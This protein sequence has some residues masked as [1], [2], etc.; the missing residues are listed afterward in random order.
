M[1]GQEIDQLIDETVPDA[2]QA[3]RKKRLLQGPKEFREMRDKAAWR[4]CWDSTDVP[5]HWPPA[6]QRKPMP[7]E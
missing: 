5:I 7:G 1:A 6:L 2:E 3:R 4:R